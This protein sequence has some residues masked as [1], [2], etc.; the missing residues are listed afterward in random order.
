MSREKQQHRGRFLVLFYAFATKECRAP[1]AAAA[2]PSQGAAHRTNIRTRPACETPAHTLSSCK[3]ANSSKRFPELP[4]NT[5]VAF[6]YRQR[7]FCPSCLFLFGKIAVFSATHQIPASVFSHGFFSFTCKTNK[8]G[9][10]PAWLF[11]N[12]NDSLSRMRIIIGYR[13]GCWVKG[14]G[15][16]CWLVYL[17]QN[18]SWFNN[19]V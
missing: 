15:W 10:V 17:S 2:V 9:E 3:Q 13:S 14:G 5:S 7:L 11:P 19:Q 4:M 18:S 1:A 16:G 6:H 8:C 12:G